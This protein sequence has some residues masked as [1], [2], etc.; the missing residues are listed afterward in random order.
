MPQQRF[1]LGPIF[2]IE[3]RRNLVALTGS[4]LAAISFK[5]FGFI[6]RIWVETSS[7]PRTA[8]RALCCYHLKS[9]QGGAFRLKSVPQ[10]EDK[11]EGDTL[12]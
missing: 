7:V 1:D 3:N 4:G 5:F 8:P 9:A 10:K 2:Q 6:F 12:N 11:A